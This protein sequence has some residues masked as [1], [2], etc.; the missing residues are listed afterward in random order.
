[1][2]DSVII[3]NYHIWVLFEGPCWNPIGS[4]SFYQE[5]HLKRRSVRKWGQ[6]GELVPMPGRASVTDGC[7]PPRLILLS[8]LFQNRFTAFKTLSP[9]L[10]LWGRQIFGAWR[11][12]WL[13]QRLEVGEGGM[14]GL[15][16]KLAQAH[17]GAT[18]L[19]TLSLC[20]TFKNEFSNP[21][22]WWNYMYR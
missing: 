13:V 19:P 16:T 2:W 15:P 1:M 8:C 7:F 3:C 4:I 9:S 17:R 20:N 11:E 18:W 22:S 14:P 6:W 5:N 21:A 12:S 10:Q